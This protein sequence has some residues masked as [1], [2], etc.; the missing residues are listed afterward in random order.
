MKIYKI[1]TVLCR[2]NNTNNTI[3]AASQ[4]YSLITRFLILDG[5][6]K[7]VCVMSARMRRNWSRSY[8]SLFCER[9][10]PLWTKIV[11]SFT[12]SLVFSR[13]PVDEPFLDSNPTWSSN[14]TTV[15][16]RLHP[17]GDN[18]LSYSPSDHEHGT[19]KWRLNELRVLRAII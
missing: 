12:P 18:W 15:G 2:L 6:G 19:S 4:E 5:P 11:E 1:P 8:V 9:P 3:I 10:S 17:H 13:I 16:L 7:A 14:H